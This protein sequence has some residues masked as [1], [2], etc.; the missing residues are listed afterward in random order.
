[1]KCSPLILFFTD[2]VF[3]LVVC[4]WDGIKCS[5]DEIHEINLEN[6]RLVATIPTD[7][8]KI[9]SIKYLYLGEL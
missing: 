3:Q 4:L 8:G 1:M 2:A 6:T 7:L 9:T 5:G